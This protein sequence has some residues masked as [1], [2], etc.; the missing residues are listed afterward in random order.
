MT[1]KKIFTKAESANIQAQ[2]DRNRQFLNKISECQVADWSELVTILANNTMLLEF[3]ASEI[4]AC[5]PKINPKVEVLRMK[6]LAASGIIS[7]Q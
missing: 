6:A 2:A 1:S 3:A 5:P 4:E 7:I